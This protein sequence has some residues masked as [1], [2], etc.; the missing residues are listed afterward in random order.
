MKDED[1]FRTLETAVPT[2]LRRVVLGG[3]EFSFATLEIDS[4]DLRGSTRALL[5][6]F[7][8]KFKGAGLCP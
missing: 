5:R 3:I 7:F 4:E 1:G 2:P 6:S 8:V